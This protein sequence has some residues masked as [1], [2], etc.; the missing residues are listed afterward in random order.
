MPLGDSICVKRFSGLILGTGN[1]RRGF[2]RWGLDRDPLRTVLHDVV[3]GRE[4]QVGQPCLVIATSG[5]GIFDHGR[6]SQA[7]AHHG[8]AGH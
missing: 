5:I 1:L 7:D 3:Y 2:C 6:N 8:Y 4:G